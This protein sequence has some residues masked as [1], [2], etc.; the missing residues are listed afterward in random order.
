MAME[1]KMDNKK[2]A[3]ELNKIANDL[4]N[5]C[6]NTRDLKEGDFLVCE[7]GYNQTNVDFYKIL[8]VSGKSVKIRKCESKIVGEEYDYDLVV[9][10]NV[11]EGPI[12]KKTVNNGCVKIYSFAYAS[13]WLGK[14]VYETTETVKMMN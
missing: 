13:K 7:W 12:M 9:P 3:N 1:N 11:F 14:P 2:I 4:I 6:G 5:R 10:T 8:A